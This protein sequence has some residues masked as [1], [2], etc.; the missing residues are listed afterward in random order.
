MQEKYSPEKLKV[1]LLSVDDSKEFYDSRAPKLFAQYGGGDWPSI[2]V[3]GGFNA[4]SSAF[5]GFGYGKVIVDEEG[6]VRS[7]NDYHFENVLEKL[8]QE[9]DKASQ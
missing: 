4:V 1:V 8:F 7:I 3:P 5:G 6:I 9:A 2:I